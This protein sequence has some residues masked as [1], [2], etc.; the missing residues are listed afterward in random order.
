M[1][2]KI[3]IFLFL[4]LFNVWVFGTF[5]GVAEGSLKSA[6]EMV[7]PDSGE[8]TETMEPRRRQAEARRRQ[9][10]RRQKGPSRQQLQRQRQQ[11]RRRR[12]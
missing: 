7:T 5:P 9:E 6:P 10:L 1:R 8:K 11:Q 2:N 3:P 12:Y 4:I